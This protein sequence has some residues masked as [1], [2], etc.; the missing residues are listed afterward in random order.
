MCRERGNRNH[1]KEKSRRK[2]KKMKEDKGE[3]RR[4]KKNKEALAYEGL[5]WRHVQ[6]HSHYWQ[7]VRAGGHPRECLAV[8]GVL[9]APQDDP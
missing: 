5:H 1:F 7:G 8:L 3:I 2:R 4:I 9:Y 6:A